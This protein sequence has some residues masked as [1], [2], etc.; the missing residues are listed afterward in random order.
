M[1]QKLLEYI[2]Y[3][4]KE[5]ENFEQVLLQT[6]KAVDCKKVDSFFELQ[7]NHD[8]NIINYQHERLIHLLVTFCFTFLM[9]VSFIGVLACVFITELQVLSNLMLIL[10]SIITVTNLF[11]IKHYY[12]LENSTQKLYSYSYKIYQ[13]IEKVNL[14]K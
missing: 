2:N 11:Y 4:E 6:E 7:K 1:K 12:F 13:L 8:R 14:Q 3:I 10:C 9:I 5:I